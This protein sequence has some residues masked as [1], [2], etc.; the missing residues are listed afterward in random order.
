MLGPGGGERASFR[1]QDLAG[2]I[3]A[4]IQ[5]HLHDHRLTPR[6]IAR[7]HHISVSYLHRLFQDQGDTVSGYIRD[8]RLRRTRRDLADA[9][10]ADVPIHRIAAR[11]GFGAPADFSRTFR[12]A[13]GES[14]REFRS[15][16]ARTARK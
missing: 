4:H 2:R 16:T 1:R 7:A 14:P 15:R 6:S 13:Y 10:L 12:M 5:V 11:W 9:V 8:Q 3:R